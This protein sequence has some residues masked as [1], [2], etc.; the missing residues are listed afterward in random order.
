MNASV[1]ED[2]VD[3]IVEET[4]LCRTGSPADVAKTMMFL[5]SDDAAFITGQVI[6]VN[7]GLVI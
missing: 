3:M 4:P 7:G 5:A 2:A 1:G 6:S